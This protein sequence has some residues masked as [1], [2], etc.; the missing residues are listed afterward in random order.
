ML[1]GPP[2]RIR[3][4]GDYCWTCINLACERNTQWPVSPPTQ[5]TSRFGPNEWLVDEIY[6]QFQRDKNSVDPAWWEFFEDYAPADYSPAAATKAPTVA[7][8]PRPRQRFPRQPPR[9]K[10]RQLRPRPHKPLASKQ[11]QNRLP[12]SR[13]ILSPP[14]CA[15]HQLGL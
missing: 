2:D 9:T 1:P 14:F 4:A 12:L 10:P 6:E 7:D 3:T 11:V 15:E 13:Q 8:A 5:V